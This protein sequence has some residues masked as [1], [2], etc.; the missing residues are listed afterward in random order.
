[1]RMTLV[2]IVLLT[3]SESFGQTP[4]QERIQQVLGKKI[5]E[6][7][8]FACHPSIVDAVRLQNDRQMAL[9]E[10][11]DLDKQWT[12]TRELTA[13]KRALQEGKAGRLLT[14]KIHKNRAIYNEGFATDNQGANVLACP[15]TSDYW[16]GDETKWQAAYNGGAG[17]TYVGPV[18]LD[19]STGVNAVQISVPILDHGKTIGVL[20]MGVRL[21]YVELKAIQAEGPS[22]A[23]PTSG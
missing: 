5:A 18:T 6:I 16:Q 3:V 17:K 19:E 14:L 1:M 15:P 13:H 4:S 20:I 11:K 8:E 7:Q 2:A 22:G 23:K 12:S 21:T 10:I 9:S